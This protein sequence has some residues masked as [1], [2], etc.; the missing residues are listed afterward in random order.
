MTNE[1]F[2]KIVLEEL[3]SLKEGQRSLEKGQI[4]LEEGQREIKKELKAITEQ[5]ADLTEFRQ[6]TNTKLDTIIE[7]NEILKE[8]IGKHEVDI[9][10]LQ[11]RIV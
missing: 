7:E 8:L 9:R 5:T 11:R 10:R 2:Q 1:E 4:S 3:K 6:E